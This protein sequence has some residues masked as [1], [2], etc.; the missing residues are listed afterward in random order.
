MNQVA[1]PYRRFSTDL[2]QV[3]VELFKGTEPV[4][5]PCIRIENRQRKKLKFDRIGLE[6]L[7]SVG[8]R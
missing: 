2:P 1:L 3:A 4:M 8:M 6:E 7:V 5:I